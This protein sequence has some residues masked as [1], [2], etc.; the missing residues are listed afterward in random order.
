MM[1]P[2]VLE[3]EDKKGKMTHLLFMQPEFL[4]STLRRRRKSL[5][6]RPTA[7]PYFLNIPSAV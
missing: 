1:D 6:V 5:H 3:T 2:D 7:C 4:K